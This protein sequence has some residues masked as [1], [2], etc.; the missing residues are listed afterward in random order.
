MAFSLPNPFRR[1]PEF[2][3]YYHLINR[4]QHLRHQLLSETR[5]IV[6]RIMTSGRNVR[7][8]T[9][10]S[11]AGIAIN[12]GVLCLND[13]LEINTENHTNESFAQQIIEYLKDAVLLLDDADFQV[14]MLNK[15]LS[16]HCGTKLRNLII[17]PETWLEKAIK[18]ETARSGGKRP[19][20][21]RLNLMEATFQDGLALLKSLGKTAGFDDTRVGA[22]LPH[23]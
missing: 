8:D 13:S 17:R 4:K 21:N 15:T 1:Q 6:F 10:T 14:H 19:E 18:K 16:K 23:R 9:V 2:I 11:F 12:N 3:S 22:L 7:K 5:M 20:T